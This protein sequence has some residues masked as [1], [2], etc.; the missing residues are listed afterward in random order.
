MARQRNR[1]ELKRPLRISR[2]LSARCP[3]RFPWCFRASCCGGICCP[4]VKSC[5]LDVNSLTFVPLRTQPAAADYTAWIR[6]ALCSLCQA[7]GKLDK[8]VDAAD[9]FAFN[10]GIKVAPLPDQGMIAI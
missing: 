2:A 10:P 9:L 7:G 4:G 6:P 3:E 5:T 1:R 8:T